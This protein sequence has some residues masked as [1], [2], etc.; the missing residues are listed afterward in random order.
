MQL[1]SFLIRWI[2]WWRALMLKVMCCEEKV[3]AHSTRLQ[4]F[5]WSQWQLFLLSVSVAMYSTLDYIL[6]SQRSGG[7]IKCLL[8]LLHSPSNLWTTLIQG[9]YQNMV[10]DLRNLS[11]CRI[12]QFW[13]WTD[14]I[15][16]SWQRIFSDSWIAFLVQRL[17]MTFFFFLIF[18]LS[19]GKSLE[20]NAQF[21]RTQVQ[22]L[23]CLVRPW[24][25]NVV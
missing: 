17:Q 16:W 18:L 19:Y 10:L 21:Y 9:K 1:K 24:L 2:A 23:P 8:G 22:S 11:K 4:M 7:I 15:S 14:F 13:V 25:T 5:I 3:T 12:I 20:P 6:V